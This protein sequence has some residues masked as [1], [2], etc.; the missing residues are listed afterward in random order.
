MKNLSIVTILLAVFLFF[1]CSETL[2][3]DPIS[4]I[5]TESFWKTES[6]VSG[7]IAGV[8]KL[9]EGQANGNL[10]MWGESRSDAMGASVGS[11]I[12]VDWYMN[13]L[14]A[15]NSE[16]NGIIGGLNWLNLYKIIHHCNLILKYTPAIEFADE[17][18]KNRYL[19]EAYSMRAF[20]YFVMARTW[21]GVPI[22]T[23][24]VSGESI[25]EVQ[26]GRDSLEDVFKLIKE[27]VGTAISLFPDNTYEQTND[28]ACWS[29]SGAYAL[30]ADVHLWTAKKMQGGE[31]DF[32]VALN[33]CSEIQKSDVSLLS[34]FGS[35][36]DYE[37]KGNKEVI[38]AIRRTYEQT[39]DANSSV[40]HWMYPTF[41]F[42]PPDIDEDIKQKLEPF[43][44]APFWGPSDNARIMYNEEDK[45]K[46]GT[47]V[48]IFTYPDG[49]KTYHSSAAVKYDGTVI[50][51]I[52]YWTDD[53][54][55]YRYADVLLMKAEA[56]N[57]LNQDPSAEM[58]EIRKRA[59]GENYEKHIFVSGDKAYN[60]Q[61]ILAER[62]RELMFEGKRWWDLIRFDK[63]FDLVPSL[64]DRKGQNHLLLFP[65]PIS[66]ISLND[67]IVQNPG[68]EDY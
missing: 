28:R 2:D 46:D 8:Y 43:G 5:S 68:Y 16:T 53:Y 41:S 26:K 56:K 21:G 57:G 60:D 4:D 38:F 36:F 48:E 25:N 59:Y 30:Q 11:A 31:A 19:A 61:E 64:Q 50:S 6:D 29:L 65:I 58:N 15:N 34:D 27:D 3:L 23:E 45:R 49:K 17:N 35:V 51:G 1:S 10:F 44:A 20:V 12:F 14:T 39:S 18:N 52:R 24:P 54:I 55:I 66:T 42:L 13:I 32:N 7:V 67:R 37:N 40:Y 22:I 9:M 47:I 63:A 62:F 33:A